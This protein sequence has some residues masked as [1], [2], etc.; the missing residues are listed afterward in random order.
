M[1]PVACAAAGPAPPATRTVRADGRS[2]GTG[3]RRRISY[4]SRSGP[5]WKPPRSYRDAGVPAN[6]DPGGFRSG[7]PD[8]SSLAAAT[9]T[10]F[11]DIGSPGTG[12]LVGQ[13]HGRIHSC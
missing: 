3:T 4:T 8:L 5:D 7:E 10:L 1:K 2:I 9:T 12:R 11:G 6:A 13:V